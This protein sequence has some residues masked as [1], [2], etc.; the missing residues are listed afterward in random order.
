[1]QGRLLPFERLSDLLV[2]RADCERIT[3]VEAGALTDPDGTPWSAVYAFVR[4]SGDKQYEAV[5]AVADDRMPVMPPL[6]Q[7][8][9][10]RLDL[11]LADLDL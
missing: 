4:R 9:L 8:I 1:M 10:R 5:V 3:L 11:Q 2:G 7:H 6:L